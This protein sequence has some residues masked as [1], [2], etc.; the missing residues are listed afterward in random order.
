LHA[1]IKW[2]QLEQQEHA[3]EH[4]NFEFPPEHVGPS[5]VAAVLANG[6][7]PPVIDQHLLERVEVD[8]EVKA[9][10]RIFRQYE[11]HVGW[12]NAREVALLQQFSHLLHEPL[13]HHR[14]FFRAELARAQQIAVGAERLVGLLQFEQ[15][16]GVGMPPPIVEIAHEAAHMLDV[17]VRPGVCHGQTVHQCRARD[18]QELLP[19]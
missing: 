12:I 17:A 10:G 14:P 8:L 2:F 15:A 7:R 13:L 18:G 4:G 3:L 11:V 5:D 19:L 1:H 6:R 16:H 9:V